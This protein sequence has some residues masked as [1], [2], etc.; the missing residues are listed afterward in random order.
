MTLRLFGTCWLT[1]QQ[2]KVLN[3]Q[4]FRITYVLLP[5]VLAHQFQG[6]HSYTLLD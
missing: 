5:K 6:L 4:F 1:S 3:K 2:V